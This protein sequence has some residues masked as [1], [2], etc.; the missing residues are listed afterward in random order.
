MMRST[1]AFFLLSHLLCGAVAAEATGT[2]HDPDK[3]RYAATRDAS[4]AIS[5]ERAARIVGGDDA[6]PGEFPY[7]VQGGLE[8]GGSLIWKDIVLSAAHC[9]GSIGTRVLVGA[10]ENSQVVRREKRKTSSQKG[11]SYLT[12]IILSTMP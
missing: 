1:A 7:F 8:C 12:P 2:L 5:A 3:T 6:M 11:K 9:I 10:V 4:R